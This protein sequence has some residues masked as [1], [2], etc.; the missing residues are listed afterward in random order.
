MFQSIKKHQNLFGM[1]IFFTYAALTLLCVFCHE[2][3]YDETQ[4]WMIARENDMAGIFNALQ[5][6][7]HPPL[8]YFILFPFA[9]LHFPLLTLSLISWTF[10]VITA[11]LILKKAPF[12][13]GLKAAVLF[14][15]GFLFYNSVTSR[16][17]CVMVL[18]LCL[19]ALLY[20]KRKQHPIVFGILVGL[21]A[22][23]HV[24]MSG[25]VGMIGIYMI[26]D[27]FKDWKANSPKQNLQ[28]V[29]GLLIAGIGVLLLVLPLLSSLGR[30]NS[31]ESQRMTAL[32]LVQRFFNIFTCIG[33][34]LFVVDSS[35]LLTNLVGGIV[36]F[37]LLGYFVLIRKYK[38][39]FIAALVFSAFFFFASQIVFY[40][41]LP[42]RAS[43]YVYTLLFIFWVAKESETPDTHELTMD[44]SRI[45]SP[46]LQK[47]SQMLI[48]VDH[49]S[50]RYITL[51]LCLVCLISVPRGVYWF[52]R[53]IVGSYSP[54]FDT[55]AYIK[56]NLMKEDTLVITNFSCCS[57]LFASEPDLHIY[58][59]EYKDF[60]TYNPYSL[61]KKQIAQNVASQHPILRNYKHIYMLYAPSVE[62]DDPN[63]TL[64]EPCYYKRIDN[65]DDYVIKSLAIYELS[66][67]RIQFYL[68]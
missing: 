62:P 8:W 45:R 44:N 49:D 68:D 56:E 60:I 30:S 1:V 20:P 25:L 65:A 67:E 64:P 31:I 66:E 9:R 24:S 14:S 36:T 51:S 48:Q 33:Q 37:L 7:G 17:Y 23:T 6:E 52:V 55:A 18:V 16:I 32:I 22:M 58:N 54:E 40:I 11:L 47:I 35:H 27:L 4:A 42:S 12:G 43:V 15:C 29:L 59:M 46:L 41:M 28:N 34:S 38:K 26:I 61:S 50:N 21:L 53:D 5:Y 57:G 3:W 39:A 10:S 2:N 13:L 63:F 19:L